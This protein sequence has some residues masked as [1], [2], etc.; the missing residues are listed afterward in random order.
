MEKTEKRQKNRAT[1]ALMR[2]FLK[3][4]KRFFVISML[5]AAL[6]AL[7]GV[8]AVDVDLAAGTA[9]VTADHDIPEAEFAKAVTD[10]GYELVK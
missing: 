6:A 8:S 2:R 1:W 10:A 4:S 7:A 3:G 5:C 9:K